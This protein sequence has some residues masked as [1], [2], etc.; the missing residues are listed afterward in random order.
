M[1]NLVKRI[2]NEYNDQLY[3]TIDRVDPLLSAL[4]DHIEIQ[5]NHYTI[6]S[7][8]ECLFKE[9]AIIYSSNIP[10]NIASRYKDIIYRQ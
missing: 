4:Y 7:M 3:T 5:F 6:K 10:M 2:V 8:R 9:K 1:L